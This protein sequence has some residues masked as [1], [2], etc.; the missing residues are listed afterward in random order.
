[1]SHLNPGGAGLAAP[2]PMLAHPTPSLDLQ[3]LRDGI[4]SRRRRLL[5]LE[6]AMVAACEAQAA[7]GRS[8]GVQ[9][10]DRETWDQPTWHR[11]LAAAAAV[12]HKFGPSM[13]QLH[14]EIDQLE[15]VLALPSLA[16]A[17]A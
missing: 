13:R 4:A 8:F 2:L 11:Y 14:R 1:M 17:V 9:M 3:Q 12:E 16:G 15:R 6:L 5:D 7:R 10:H